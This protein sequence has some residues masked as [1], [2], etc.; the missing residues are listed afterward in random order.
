MEKIEQGQIWEVTTEN[1]LTGKGSKTFDRSLKLEK[2]EKFEIRYPYA[3][4]F[5]TE[6]DKYFQADE[7]VIFENC[8]YIGKVWDKIRSQNEAS[9]S[10]I[11]RLRLYD[12]A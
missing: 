2:G 7:S 6:D 5:R 8:K 10:D 3:W 4:H 9:L 12:R 1:F 11:L